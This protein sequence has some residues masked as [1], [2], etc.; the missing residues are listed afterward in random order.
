MGQGARG[1]L[2]ALFHADTDLKIAA[3]GIDKNKKADMPAGE[4]GMSAVSPKVPR[5]RGQTIKT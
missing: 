2:R 1:N 4:S 3:Q 5:G